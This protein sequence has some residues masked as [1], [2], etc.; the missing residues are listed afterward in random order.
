MV[1]AMKAVSQGMAVSIAAKVFNVPQKTSKK[2][3]SMGQNQV[4][5]L[6]CLVYMAQRGFP[7][8]RTMTMATEQAMLRDLIRI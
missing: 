4:Q 3:Y 6:Y 2:R 7:L 8:T 5:I 1:S